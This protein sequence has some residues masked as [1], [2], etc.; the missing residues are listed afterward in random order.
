MLGIVQAAVEK[1][2]LAARR[3]KDKE[4]AELKDMILNTII[5]VEPN[6]RKCAL[7]QSQFAAIKAS[8]QQNPA[9]A[10][11][12]NALRQTINEANEMLL[13]QTD[14]YLKVL[15][16]LAENRFN[17]FCGEIK[18]KREEAI[19]HFNHA[20]QLICELSG[21]PAEPP[22]KDTGKSDLTQEE[23]R[24]LGERIK[25]YLAQGR[26]EGATSENREQ[27]HEAFESIRLGEECS[28]EFHTLDA[29]IGEIC[30]SSQPLLEASISISEKLLERARQSLDK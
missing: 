9:A 8:R 15:T 30:E 14:G 11:L 20:Y 17:Y 1:M 5:E 23:V 29:R 10:H 16:D 24:Q 2:K 26:I 13:R 3:L 4:H 6:V 18:E 27:Y 21:V 28:Q 12:V 22:G 19:G 7:M 25:E